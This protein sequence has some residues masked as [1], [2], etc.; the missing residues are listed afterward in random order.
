[1]VNYMINPLYQQMVVKVF[2]EQL[3]PMTTDRQLTE[4]DLQI[5]SNQTPGM[6]EHVGSAV[7]FL[8]TNFNSISSKGDSDPTSISD[9]DVM[10][11]SKAGVNLSVL[12]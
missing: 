7:K 1:M 9:Q 3:M 11:F 2:N 5:L 10:A 8:L 4:K 12:V 6:P